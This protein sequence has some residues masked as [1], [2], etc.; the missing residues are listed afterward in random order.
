MSR[1]FSA[2][3]SPSIAPHADPA[4]VSAVRRDIEGLRLAVESVAAAVEALPDAERRALA[5]GLREAG[6]RFLDVA[7]AA[8]GHGR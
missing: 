8:E 4:T 7:W 1:Q 5:A 6:V 3:L 2:P